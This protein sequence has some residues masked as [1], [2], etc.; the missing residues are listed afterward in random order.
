MEHVSHLLRRDALLIHVSVALG[1]VKVFDHLEGGAD[2][3]IVILFGN[4]REVQYE[5]LF[6]L[7]LEHEVAEAGTFVDFGLDGEE[8]VIAASGELCRFSSTTPLFDGSHASV[9]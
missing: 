1:P 6:T 4:V 7:I 8:A 3:T 5:G 9:R 2:T